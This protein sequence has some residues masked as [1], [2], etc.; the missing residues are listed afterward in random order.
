MS[1]TPLHSMPNPA[2][3]FAGQG[4]N[5]QA[6]LSDAAQAPATA[7]NLRE[8]LAEARRI[9]GPAAR[10][11]A[12]TC[13][14]A[15]E[16]LEQ[17]LEGDA[18]TAAAL[19]ASPAVSI[20]GIVLSQIATIEQL[21]NLGVIIDETA[22]HSQ[23]TLGEM[24]VDKP[25]EA[26]A[27]ALLMGTAA[28]AVGGSDTRSQMLSIRGLSRDFITENLRGNTVIAVVNAR[29]HFVLSGSPEDLAA[30]RAAL[31][32]AVQAFNDSLE[33]RTIGGDP[34]SRNTPSCPWLF[35]STTPF[36]RPLPSAPSNWPPPVASTLKT[37]ASRQNP[38]WST[39]TTGRTSWLS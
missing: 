30:T 29:Q 15:I 36:S 37:L 35:L 8:V 38:S 2:V 16:R 6:T 25:A 14:G 3:I 21:R 20:P 17:L 19:D 28:N 13:P 18:A 26:L 7:Q 33:E 11:I 22:G 27:L 32:S 24:A 4:S 5:W 39:S 23:G 9:T 34:L 1:L 10:T 12:S 31:D